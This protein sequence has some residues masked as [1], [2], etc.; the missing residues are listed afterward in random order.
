VPVVERNPPG[1]EVAWFKG[2]GGSILN[3]VAMQTA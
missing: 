1:T 3:V 2:S